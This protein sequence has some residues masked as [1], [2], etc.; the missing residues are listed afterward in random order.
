MNKQVK[1]QI[2]DALRKYCGR[3]AS[4]NKAA[5][6]LKD[7]SAATVSQILNDKWDLIA[8][9]MW[10]RVAA[11]IGFSTEG[12]IL[13]DTTVSNTLYLLLADAQATEH[14]ESEVHAIVGHAGCGKTATAQKYAAENKNAYHLVCSEY[15]NRKTFLLELM[16]AMGL[17]SSGYMV[18]EMIRHIVKELKSQKCPLIVMDEADKLSDQ[19][20]YF[21]ITMYNQLEDYCGLVLLATDFLEKRIKRGVQ[22]KRKGYNEIFSRIGRRF[23]DL[24]KKGNTYDDLAA[25]CQANGLIDPHAI[26]NIID[27]SESDLRRVKKLTKANIKKAKKAA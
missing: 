16:E 19:V 20:L 13:V 4:Q 3:F 12:W 1:Q 8:D 15:W 27:G 5:N 18:N 11:Q 23:V 2:A 10:R 24:N 21:F 9:E 25:I 6:S 22:N 14:G 26:E 7:V 17:D